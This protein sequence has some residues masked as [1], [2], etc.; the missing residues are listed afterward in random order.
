VRSSVPKTVLTAGFQQ[1]PFL[2]LLEVAYPDQHDPLLGDRLK[3]RDRPGQSLEG[4]AGEDREAHRVEEPRLV[5]LGGVE[6][7][8]RVELADHPQPLGTHTRDGSEAAVA[9]PGQH[10]WEAVGLRGSTN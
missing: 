1:P 4:G 2:V 6:V 7:G 5:V 9:V 10:Q 3:L 8:V